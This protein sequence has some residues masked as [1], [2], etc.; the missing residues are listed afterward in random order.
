MLKD[1]SGKLRVRCLLKEYAE[2]AECFRHTYSTIWQSGI[3][4][5]TFSAAIFGFF[6]SFQN[7][8]NA[9]LLYLPLIS[10]SSIIVWWLMI[11]E[12]MNRY[13]DIREERCRRIEEELSGAIPNLNMRHFRSYGATKKRFLRVRWGVRVLAVI[14]IVL[15]ILLVLNFVFL[16]RPS[17]DP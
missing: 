11:F 15:M 8:L 2:C 12:P 1:E 5:A 7:I 6:L 14:I 16:P 13:G 9:Y 17:L 3:L 10:L 4:F